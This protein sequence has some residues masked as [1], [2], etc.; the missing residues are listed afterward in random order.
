MSKSK[1]AHQKIP[2]EE[3]EMRELSEQPTTSTPAEEENFDSNFWEEVPNIFVHTIVSV[4]SC[5]NRIES[6]I[7]SWNFKS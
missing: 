6:I 1:V 2:T 5:Y 4:F 3:R 7:N